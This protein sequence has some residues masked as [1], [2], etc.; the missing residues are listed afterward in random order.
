MGENRLAAEI[1]KN[2]ETVAALEALQQHE[3]EL[4]SMYAQSNPGEISEYKRRLL[5]YALEDMDRPKD[6]PRLD[7]PNARRGIS[8]E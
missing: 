7:S 5:R 6:A 2:I 1:R 4:L 3:P 8:N